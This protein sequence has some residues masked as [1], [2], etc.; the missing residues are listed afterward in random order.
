V[1]QK[2]CLI[3]GPIN[4]LRGK[5]NKGSLV[6]SSNAKRKTFTLSS[7]RIDNIKHMMKTTNQGG[8][9]VCGVNQT[10]MENICHFS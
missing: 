5:K 9:G 7:A 3:E 4:F 2:R 8:H 6:V 10:S 1:R